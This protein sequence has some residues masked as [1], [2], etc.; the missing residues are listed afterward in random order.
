MTVKPRFIISFFLLLYFMVMGL[1]DIHAQAPLRIYL[2]IDSTGNKG[3]SE[4]T[5]LPSEKFQHAGHEYFCVKTGARVAWLKLELDSV[6]VSSFL[7]LDNSNLDSISFYT[8]AT[9]QG[10]LYSG[11][12]VR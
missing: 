11:S 1:F 12:Y 2:Y 3:I 9:E 10:C 8:G 5:Q 7:L 6:R 4:I